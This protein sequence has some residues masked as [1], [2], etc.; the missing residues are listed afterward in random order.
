L[1][2]SASKPRLK[3]DQQGNYHETDLS[4]TA[5]TTDLSEVGTAK[6]LGEAQNLEAQNRDKLADK[7]RKYFQHSRILPAQ[8]IPSCTWC[9]TRFGI[10]LQV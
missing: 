8:L 9:H 10:V 1:Q 4:S 5:N 2:K 3:A 6:Q 7:Q